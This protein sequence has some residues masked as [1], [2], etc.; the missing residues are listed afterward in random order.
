[1]HPEDIKIEEY[2]SLRNS[3]D[4]H[5][6][7]IPEIFAIMVAATSALLGYGISSKSAEVFLI[8]LLIIFPC[9]FLIL[10][11]MNEVMLKGA[12]IK[13]Q[14]EQN[15]WGW[16]S[17]L[18][19]RRLIKEKNKKR[20]FVKAA[21]DAYAFVLIIDFLILLC[22]SGLFCISD[23]FIRFLITYQISKLLCGLL[24]LSTGG[25]LVGIIFLT[26]RLNT[27][28]L[29]AYTYENEIKVLKDLDDV[30][31]RKEESGL[32]RRD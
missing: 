14:Y 5:M 4:M 16:E 21:E 7:L 22:L 29:K 32:T 25:L 31:K 8:P 18:F 15:V 26:Y 1:M 30:F 9:T 3:I 10:S 12:Y 11:Q 28:I 23:F 19:E 13:K 17:T 27:A 20:L 24:C 6:K 2:K